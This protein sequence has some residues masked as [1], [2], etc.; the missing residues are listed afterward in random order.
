[1]SL[2]IP[3][4]TK[5]FDKLT[6]IYGKAF[7]ARWEGLSIEDVKADWAQELAGFAENPDAIAY[8]L[9]HIPADRPPTVLQFKELC[10]KAPPKTLAAISYTSSGAG[11]DAAKSLTTII[12]G[13][14][15]DPKAW[16]KKL[17]A[18]EE[19]GERLSPIQKGMWREALQI[20]TPIE[21]DSEREARVERESIQW[22][23]AA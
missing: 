8:A 2:P 20:Y 7:K 18:R 6:L 15:A 22:E 16:A 13:N 12:T 9:K 11:I 14:R 17:R 5:I 21:T 3:W 10:R 23:Q 4:V 19:A 1:M